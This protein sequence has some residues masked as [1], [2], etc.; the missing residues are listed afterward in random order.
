MKGRQINADLGF[1]GVRQPSN[2]SRLKYPN[3]EGIDLIHVS[4]SNSPICTGILSVH[5]NKG[6]PTAYKFS[7]YC[8]S[9]NN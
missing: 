8:L 1:F 2:D 5:K 9:T 4:Q 6:I 7:F 3:C